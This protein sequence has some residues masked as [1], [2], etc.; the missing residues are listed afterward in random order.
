MR[1]FLLTG[2][3]AVAGF[4]VV[5][6]IATTPASAQVAVETP[7]G[8][9]A[10]GPRGYYRDYDRPAYRAYGYDRGYRGCRTVTIERDDG[11][12]RRIRRCD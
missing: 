7:F 3:L 2:V 9:V 11:S 6:P 4:S 8:G 5:A 10:V 12:V 1:T